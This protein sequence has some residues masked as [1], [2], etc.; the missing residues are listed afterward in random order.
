[1]DDAL[2]AFFVLEA[3]DILWPKTEDETII[4]VVALE[5]WEGVEYDTLGLRG[6]YPE[7]VFPERELSFV[8]LIDM[9]GGSGENFA[10]I[11][12][13]ARLWRF[14]PDPNQFKMVGYLVTYDMPENEQRTDMHQIMVK[15][16]Y[17]TGRDALVAYIAQEV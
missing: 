8:R 9:S 5:D 4:D 3:F 7:T 10:D 11:P 1:M 12:E 16:N 6:A 13:G 17:D 2:Y 15:Q 14:R